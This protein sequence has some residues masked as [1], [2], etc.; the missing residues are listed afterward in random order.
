[1][2]AILKS[3]DMNGLVGFDDFQPEDEKDFGVWLTVQVGP[4]DQDGGH[5]FQIFICTPNWL[6]KEC[7]SL[8]A[9]WGRH[10]LIVCEYDRGLIVKSISKYI[11]SCTGDDFWGGAQ[12]I[13]RIGAWEFEDYQP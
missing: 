8:G 9:V 7:L 1:M 4:D 6:K 11:E 10:M 3:I 12:K 5:L 13:S 2:K